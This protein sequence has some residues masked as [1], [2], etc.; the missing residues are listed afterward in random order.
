MAFIHR[1]AFLA[2]CAA[3][4]GQGIIFFADGSTSEH[5]CDAVEGWHILRRAKEEGLLTDEEF[6]AVS[7]QIHSCSFGNN[8][9]YEILENF[10]PAIVAIVFETDDGGFSPFIPGTPSMN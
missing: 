5:F 3:H 10:E 8:A 6:K 9:L 4:G 1:S 2:L 7:E